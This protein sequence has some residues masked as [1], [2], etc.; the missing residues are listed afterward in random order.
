MTETSKPNWMVAL[1]LVFKDLV[2]LSDKSD[3]EATVPEICHPGLQCPAK[4]EVTVDQ[5]ATVSHEVFV[6]QRSW[7]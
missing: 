2:A 5:L 1:K 7:I 4:I 3:V 6:I